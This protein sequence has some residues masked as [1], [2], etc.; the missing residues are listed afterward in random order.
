MRSPK[1]REETRS[2][3]RMWSASAASWRSSSG[4]LCAMSATTRSRRSILW[5]DLLRR[6]TSLEADVVDARQRVVQARLARGQAATE[7][8]SDAQVKEALESVQRELAYWKEE[9]PPA[10]PAHD[11]ALW[12]A[13]G[14]DARRSCPSTIPHEVSARGRAAREL[15]DR[16]DP[17]A[18]RARVAQ[19]Y[20][21][22]ELFVLP[23]VAAA[24]TS[25]RPSLPL[26]HLWS[27]RG[28]RQSQPWD[29]LYSQL[30]WRSA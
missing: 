30:R 15:L 28:K 16:V 3:E 8:Q 27:E 5:V 12:H 22:V 23:L 6:R 13:C 7:L 20:A 24:S 14:A 9:T 17:A 4:R 26:R 25:S 19:A 21:K 18:P 1:R 29:G 11:L 10:P 2:F